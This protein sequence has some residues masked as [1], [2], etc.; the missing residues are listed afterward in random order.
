MNLPTTGAFLILGGVATM[1]QNGNPA[2]LA[3]TVLAIAFLWL[4]YAASDKR[5]NGSWGIFATLAMIITGALF[6]LFTVT[7]AVAAVSPCI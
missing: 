4:F 7:L 6:M 3:I 1:T 5:A 2:V